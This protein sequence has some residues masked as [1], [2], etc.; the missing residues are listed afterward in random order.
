MTR[1][2]IVIKVL[3]NYRNINYGALMCNQSQLVSKIKLIISKK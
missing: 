1:I 3:L 2:L